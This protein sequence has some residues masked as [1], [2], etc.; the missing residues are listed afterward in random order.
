VAPLGRD[1]P[2]WIASTTIAIAIAT[3][4]YPRDDVKEDLIAGGI[5]K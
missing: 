4:K 1:L 5:A 2:H 3:A